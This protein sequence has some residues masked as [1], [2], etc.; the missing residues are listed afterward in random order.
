[1]PET[2]AS[3]YVE[4]TIAGWGEKIEMAMIDKII[5]AMIGVRYFPNIEITL[6]L[7]SENTNTS[8]KYIALVSRELLSKNGC[9]AISCVTA[10]VRGD[11][12]PRA[13]RY[14][15]TQ[16]NMLKRGDTFLPKS[17]ILPCNLP[18]ATSASIGRMT[19]ERI[20][21]KTTSHHEGP[22]FKPKYGG[23]IRLP[24]PNIIEKTAK[25]AIKAFLWNFMAANGIYILSVGV[26]KTL[27][28][29][30]FSQ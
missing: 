27:N 23:R 1:M 5:M 2:N 21:P 9:M 30:K 29:K 14:T 17:Y 22:A 12:N 19:A 10:A 8:K 6:L 4:D 11:G 26:I 3:S 13:I 20:N 15:I 25:P 24:A 28:I 7:L 16:Y 18:W